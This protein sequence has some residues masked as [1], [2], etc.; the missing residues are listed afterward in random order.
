MITELDL[1]DDSV[2]ALIDELLQNGAM[3]HVFSEDEKYAVINSIR[4]SGDQENSS[5]SITEAWEVF[6]V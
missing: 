4:T 1:F 5:L 6:M 3:T 2:I